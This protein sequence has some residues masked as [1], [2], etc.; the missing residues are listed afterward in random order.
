MKQQIVNLTPHC[1]RINDGTEY[2]AS[3]AVARVAAGY[4]DFDE[5]GVCSAEFGQVSGVPEPSDGV[6]YVVSGMVSAAM[7]NRLDVVAPATGHPE[8]VRKDGQI[9][10]VPGWVK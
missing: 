4:S 1:I 9:Y 5:R 10:S 8:A 2:P 6:L 3:G 7:P